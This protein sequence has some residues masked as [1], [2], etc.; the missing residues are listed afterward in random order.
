MK[1]KEKELRLAK[2]IMKETILKA[3]V[4]RKGEVLKKA[5]E[6][7]IKLKRK[8]TKTTSWSDAVPESER[9]TK[10]EDGAR[11]IPQFGITRNRPTVR[12]VSA[13][14]IKLVSVTTQM[15][16]TTIN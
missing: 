10:Y 14:T 2:E 5:N 13:M 12:G 3:K 16:V 9:Y 11:R 6:R 8:G 4:D 15:S 7:I 1:L